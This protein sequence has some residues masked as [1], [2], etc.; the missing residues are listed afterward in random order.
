MDAQTPNKVSDTVDEKGLVRNVVIAATP[1]VHFDLSTPE[2]RQAYNNHLTGP[3]GGL[4][5][6][7]PFIIIL[8][9][10]HA[11]TIVACWAAFGTIC[12]VML[13]NLYRSSYDDRFPPVMILNAGSMLTY[14]GLG[15]AYSVDHS[16]TY[17]L[18]SPIIARTKV[19]PE[20]ARHPGFMKIQYILTLF[21]T[22]IFSLMTLL[23]WLNFG[24]YSD[25]PEGTKKGFGQSLIGTIL[26]ILL[27]IL[28]LR[29]SPV[30]L[31]YLMSKGQG[32]TAQP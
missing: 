16:I 7:T 21:W 1:C 15:I 20:V 19:S 2:G 25:E 31:K 24:L 11:H 12:L 10:G 18:I 30:L 3:V 4:L 28:G 22:V 9:V 29:V 8:T 32:Q 5:T 27:P 13:T 23:G 14:L 17:L 26:P 6:W